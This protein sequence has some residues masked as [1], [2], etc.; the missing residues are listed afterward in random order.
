MVDF[1]S[2]LATAFSTASPPKSK[3]KNDFPLGKGRLVERTAGSRERIQVYMQNAELIIS[4]R[5]CDRYS[6]GE[7]RVRQTLF[8]FATTFLLS[9]IWMFSTAYAA[10]GTCDSMF[11]RVR[12]D[13]ASASH[14][15]V[16]YE[17]YKSR[18]DSIVLQEPQGDVPYFAIGTQVSLTKFVPKMMLKTGRV[19]YSASY[20]FPSYEY[21]AGQGV[22][23][24]A[25]TENIVREALEMGY[26]SVP[27]FFM[28]LSPN[29]KNVF[30]VLDDVRID[31]RPNHGGAYSPTSREIFNILGSPDLLARS[32]WFKNGVEISFDEIFLLFV[33]AD[34]LGLLSKQQSPVQSIVRAQ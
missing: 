27:S 28:K 2:D 33:E 12:L 15:H 3:A 31:F 11:S 7:M 10:V 34:K 30:V 16:S 4:S 13:P 22:R 9:T 18:W 17:Q 5:D 21:W 19:V 24:G 29:T 26:M 32:R 23:V 8:Y 20:W 25:N 6:C 14:L 1:T